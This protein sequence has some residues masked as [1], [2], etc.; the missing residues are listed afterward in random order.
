MD[1]L[2]AGR[3]DGC[4]TIAGG[5]NITESGKFFLCPRGDIRASL[6][7]AENV[8]CDIVILH[9][10]GN[11]NAVQLNFQ[12][13]SRSRLKCLFLSENCE[14]LKISV[15][16]SLSGENSRAHIGNFFCG[17][18][19]NGHSISVSQVHSAADGKSSL[20]S[21]VILDGSATS[22]FH[23]R[24]DIAPNAARSDA[25]QRNDNILLSDGARAISCPQLNIANND[26]KCSHGAATGTID[27]AAI[28]YAMSRGID[29]ATCKRLMAEGMVAALIGWQL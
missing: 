21:K 27:E 3:S 13:L 29:T 6:T 25:S 1:R 2:L 16:L 7:V 12:L 8:D 28:F 10:G 22:E 18:G 23:G 15:T 19:S 5:G 20:L 26:V 9:I 24:I 17:Q 4:S 14:N 11:A